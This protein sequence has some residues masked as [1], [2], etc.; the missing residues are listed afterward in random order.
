MKKLWFDILLFL[1]L[2]NC[3]FA[4]S[5]SI[6]NSSFYDFSLIQYYDFL[7]KLKQNPDIV[8]VKQK[9][10]QAF[11]DS[12]KIA[13]SMRH[14][15]DVDINNAIEMAK[16]ENKLNIPTTYFILH[17]ADYY[18]PAGDFSTHNNTILSQMLQIQ[19]LGHEIGVHN[20]LLTLQIVYN[21]SPTLFLKNELEWMRANGLNIYGSASHGSSYCHE[22]KY[23]NFYFFRYCSENFSSEKYINKDFVIKDQ[24]T[25]WFEKADFSDFDLNYEGYFIG[26]TKYYSDVFLNSA[27][28]RDNPTKIDISTWK[29]GDKIVILTHPIHWNKHNNQQ[30]FIYP[31]PCVNYFSVYIDGVVPIFPINIEIY[32][33]KGDLL[34]KRNENYNRGLTVNINLGKG[35]YLLKISYKK[36]DD[37]IVL[38]K[39]LLVE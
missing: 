2:F 28:E 19:S 9:D 24:D 4:N 22:Y 35:L 6:E 1:L 14:D 10:F 3:D 26:Y 36:N 11:N 33:L 12:T 37:Y 20:D 31:N 21:I 29:K 25:I 16:L 7:V 17:T 32:N 8:F 5:Q 39:K 15:V 18:H 27:G 34:N 30:C 13:F 38:F 23:L